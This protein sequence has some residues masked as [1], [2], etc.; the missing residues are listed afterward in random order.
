MRNNVLRVKAPIAE[1]Y[2]ISEVKFHDIT[3]GQLPEFVVSPLKRVSKP[4]PPK[5]LQKVKEGKVKEK[6]NS[7]YR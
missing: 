3:V 5:K 4:V 2:K 7:K 1:K 6:T